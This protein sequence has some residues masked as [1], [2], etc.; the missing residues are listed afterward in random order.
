MLIGLSGKM[1]VGKDTVAHYLMLKYGFRRL[2]FADYLKQA[3][4][5]LGWDG[6][7]DEKGRKLL[8]RLG[9]D[10]REYN[11]AT[12]INVVAQ[13][14]YQVKPTG[15]SVVITDVRFKNEVDWIMREGGIVV[16]VARD[17]KVTNQDISETE[18]DQFPFTYRID[19]PLGD[20]NTLYSNIE[21]VLRQYLDSEAVKAHRQAEP[22]H[23]DQ[24]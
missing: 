21:V 14:W 13:Q 15:A 1:Q 16:R 24:P 9:Q 2:A 8:Q 11:P 6:K 4:V 3:A 5:A 18:L 7:K 20:F 19:S 17:E 22:A 12:W 23:S 10:V